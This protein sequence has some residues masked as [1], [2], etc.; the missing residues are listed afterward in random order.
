MMVE[1]HTRKCTCHGGS[2]MSVAGQS[3]SPCSKTGTLPSGSVVVP[4]EQWRAMG[5][6]HN[7]EEFNDFL[8]RLTVSGDRREHERLEAIVDIRLS[9]LDREEE[10][11]VSEDT[12]TENLSR[13]GARV[14]SRMGVTKGEVVLF[15]EELSAFRTRAQI[16]DVTPIGDQRHRLH[17]RFLDGQAPDTLLHRAP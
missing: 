8:S 12:A 3:G 14:L 2:W 11:A 9:R 15:E 7:V 4:L 17:L 1:L 6:P 10:A 16:Q 13:G 5:K